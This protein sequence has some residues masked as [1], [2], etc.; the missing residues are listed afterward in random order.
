SVSR[1][2]LQ[3]AVNTHTP[4]P[5]RTHN[6]LQSPYPSDSPNSNR[7]RPESLTSSVTR[8]RLRNGLL[9]N[10]LSPGGGSIGR[11]ADRRDPI[12]PSYA[13]LLQLFLSPSN[14]IADLQPSDACDHDISVAYDC[15]FDDLHQPRESFSSPRT[16]TPFQINEFIRSGHDMMLAN[17]I[18]EHDT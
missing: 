13:Q 15:F 1:N 10:V 11:V 3:S 7:I 6:R 9:S 18:N 5:K 4:S 16:G 12:S 14:F 8:T 2:A 17:G